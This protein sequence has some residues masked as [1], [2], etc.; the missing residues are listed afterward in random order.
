MNT[1]PRS[2]QHDHRAWLHA[3]LS[4]AVALSL[5]VAACADPVT[6]RGRRAW[7]RAQAE[8]AAAARG[9]FI[10]DRRPIVMIRAWNGSYGP[11]NPLG[12]VPD[13][14]G[15]DAGEHLVQGLE[16]AY[17]QG[18][19]RMM[20]VLPAGKPE[21]EKIAS[22]LDEWW[23]RSPRWRH[24]M[25]AALQQWTARRPDATLGLYTGIYLR[26]RKAPAEAH[27]ARGLRPW[28]E[29]GVREFA[30]DATSP[31]ERRELFAWT[32][33]WLAERGARAIMEAYPMGLG[34]GRIEEE[35]IQRAP[36]M[37][38]E[39]FAVA[40][41]K[42]GAWTFDP[43]TT[44]VHVGLG[45]GGGQPK[46]FTVEE[47]K[48]WIDRGFI[49]MVYSVDNETRMNALIAHRMSEREDGR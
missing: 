35:W 46:P 45:V 28:L 40:V 41:D 33:Q 1:A 48:A 21:N 4:A 19:R 49:P 27:V 44:E 5:C 16:R 10:V 12:L 38:L 32:S 15:D 26:G 31:H 7:E 47:A 34:T 8:R 14:R 13:A 17:A 2:A 25:T 24:N 37:A 43:E 23:Q 6:E 20:L 42:K 9:G 3:L 30:L 11:D 29:A 36:V 18:W 22:T 39:E